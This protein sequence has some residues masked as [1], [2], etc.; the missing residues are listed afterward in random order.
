MPLFFINIYAVENN[1]SE[2]IKHIKF[3]STSHQLAKSL[4]KIENV[5]IRYPHNQSLHVLYA[6]LL[7]W[8]HQPLRAKEEITPFKTL[9][10]K[11]YRKIY[12]A[13]AIDVVRKKDT[14]SKKLKFLQNL[15][16]FARKSYD[17]ALTEIQ[18]NIK[19]KRIKKALYLTEKLVKIYPKS[20]EI[21]EYDA[22]LLFWNKKY[23]KSRRV[24]LKLNKGKNTYKQQI[25]KL[26]KIISRSIIHKK[27]I[28]KRQ[29]KYAPIVTK[30]MF[31]LGN[32]G[33][34][35][36]AQIHTDNTHYVEAKFPLYHYKIYMKIE[37][38]H[39][40][41]LRDIKISGELYP[42]FSKPQWG[43]LSFSYTPKADFFSQYSIGWH[44][45][46]GWKNWEFGIGYEFNKY[47][48]LDIGLFSLEYSYYFSEY[49]YAKQ[50]FYYVPKTSSSACKTLLKYQ[51]N[52]NVEWFIQYTF[53]RA[54]EKIDDIDILRSENGKDLQL[55]G[56]LPIFENYSI[57]AN[58]GKEWLE[59]VN[60]Q[61]SRKYFEIFIRKHW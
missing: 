21:Q 27:V 40:Y 4:E 32:R 6:K 51:T 35:N 14:I 2:E 57:G 47:K 15:A 36:S 13:W 34:D 61:Y 59:D 23:K 28:V 50:I 54:N 48:A 9:H 45:Y 19:I 56:E 29:Q 25:V 37:D 5:L 38:T 24:Y 33:V 31:G 55:G 30:F 10:L 58:I 20:I 18:T 11:L 52:K 43:Y 53:S 12:I 16:P 7:F 17:I 39:R 46:Y 44:H 60:H 22:R 26:N 41:G 42:E 3:L 8:N 49:L 1:L